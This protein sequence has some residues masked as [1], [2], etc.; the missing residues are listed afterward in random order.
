MQVERAPLDA[1]A[2]RAAIA[3]P[4]SRL[5]VVDETASTNADLLAAAAQTPDGAVLV[6]EH[7]TS[8]RGRLDRSWE[9]PPRAGL[10]FSVLLRPDVPTPTWA[11]LPLLAGV[12]L[13]DAIGD[14][15]A[16]AALKWPN[17][18]LLGADERKAGGILVQV[19]GDAAVIGMGVNVSTT[20]DELPVPTATSL[21]MAGATVTDR[22]ALLVAVLSE[23]AGRYAQWRA[24]R[25]DAGASGLAADYRQRCV[26]FGRQVTVM[27]AGG[28]ALSGLA[29]GLDADGR[30]VLDRDGA[31]CVVAAGDVEHLR[32]ATG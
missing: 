3:G 9:S 10:T 2:L 31:E 24:A 1:E 15:G 22:G 30:L 4:W 8:G 23:L 20:A 25:G 13:C 14:T 28:A 11:W 19:N 12:A 27:L 7:Q 32:A 21:A 18:L 17:D 5:T 29:T 6:A 16:R 26:T